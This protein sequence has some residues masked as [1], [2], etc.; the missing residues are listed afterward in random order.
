[1]AI[2]L[3]AMIGLISNKDHRRKANDVLFKV[4]FRILCRPL[5]AVV[6]FH[7]QQYRPKGVGF[8]VA[9]HTTPMDVAILGADCTYSLVSDAKKQIL[10]KLLL[11]GIFHFHYC[12]PC[13]CLSWDFDIFN[14]N[15]NCCRPIKF[16]RV[17]ECVFCVR[18]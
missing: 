4:V 18:L 17:Y 10:I 15:F 3:F 11:L 12:W 16:V 14:R 6:R 5:S 9:N 8:C 13:P 7:N 2:V 1:M